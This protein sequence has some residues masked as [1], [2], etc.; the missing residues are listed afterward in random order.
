VQLKIRLV[1]KHASNKF[2][3]IS[4]VTV[5]I[6]W[7]TGVINHVVVISRFVTMFCQVDPDFC[8]AKSLTFS[9]FSFL[10]FHISVCMRMCPE[11]HRIPSVGRQVC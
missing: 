7:A 6:L 10:W 8:T 11:Y 3:G 9:L 1:V 2:A 4:H 5:K